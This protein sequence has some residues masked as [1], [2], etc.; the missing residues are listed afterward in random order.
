MTKVWDKP[1]TKDTDW[2]G[3]ASTGGLPVSGRMIQAFIKESLALASS[4]EDI[5]QFVKDYLEE[6]GMASDEGFVTLATEQIIKAVK[7]FEKG[8]KINGSPLITFDKDL[9]A[10]ILRANLVTE[11]GV[12][13]RALLDEIKVPTIM[14]GIVT[15]E[16]TISK[17]DGVL[18]V[19]KAGLDKEEL[20][21]ILE[22]E[23]YVTQS[24]VKSYN[25]EELKKYV[26]KTDLP[27]DIVTASSDQEITGIKNFAN[28][29]EIAGIK[30]YN[31]QDGT[32][33]LDGN[34]V[35]SGGIT[36]RGT[37]TTTTPSLFEALPIDGR[38]I[39]RNA[40]GV[41]Y[42]DEDA[43]N[44]S[45][46][47]GVADS[48]E[49]LNIT[50]KPEWIGAS[51]PSY[52][53]SEIDE[54]PDL[55]IYA[56]SESVTEALTKY[57]PLDTAQ[58]ITA[59]HDFKKGLLID[60]LAIYKSTTDTIYIDANVVVR[61]GV[62]SRGTNKSITPSIFESLP[63]DEHTIKRNENGVLYVDSSSLNIGGGGGGNGD[64]SDVA[65][66]LVLERLADLNSATVG[67]FFT[68]ATGDDSDS[69][70]RPNKG[71][72]TGLT[73]GLDGQQL[74]A[75][76]LAFDASENVYFRRAQGGTWGSWHQFLTEDNYNLYA[77][78]ITGGTVNGDVTISGTLAS[79]K[80]SVNNTSA[81]SGVF[82]TP[83]T[84]IAIASADG[85]GLVIH[86]LATASEN[87][88]LLRVWQG[89]LTGS[90]GSGK[91][92]FSIQSG[93]YTN[94]NCP[95]NAL[96]GIFVGSANSDV[97]SASLY[98]NRSSRNYIASPTG[99][100]IAIHP[101]G[102]L[103]IDSLGYL[104]DGT[105]FYPASNNAYSLGKEGYAWNKI[106][107]TTIN[108][109]TINGGSINLAGDLYLPYGN[110]VI[111]PSGNLVGTLKFGNDTTNYRSIIGTAS[112]K[113]LIISNASLR[114]WKGSD[115]KEY[116]IF[117]SSMTSISLPR[118]VATGIGTTSQS[119]YK[120]T[121]NGIDATFGA[122]DTSGGPYIWVASNHAL[123][124]ATNGAER[125]RITN[126][127]NV[128]IG[129]Q[130]AS[131]KFYVY[132]TSGW[133]SAFTTTNSAV[134]VSHADGYGLS[135]AS[136]ATASENKYLLRV[137]QGS[138]SGSVGTGEALFE[139]RSN[140]IVSVGG[141]LLVTGGITGR[142]TSDR[143]LKENIRKFSASKILM[144]LG[145]VYEYEY[146][147]SEVQKNHIYEGTHYGLIY[148][149]VKGTTLDVMCHENENG[150]GSLNYLE[151]S[152]ISLIAGATMENVDEIAKLKKENRALSKRVE[153][154]ERRV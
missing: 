133:T 147:D 76:Q 60:G 108:C 83:K 23:E 109:T 53:Y 100:K 49:W 81:W 48:V 72:I 44:I 12:I 134:G 79:A 122:N 34:L 67:R 57:V 39:K 144:S 145:G 26:L 16:D 64:A 33:F 132:N 9:N 138:L 52:T 1:I 136:L 51:K 142:Y 56:T 17:A 87:K 11:G 4:K 104:F 18:R 66:G 38:T 125:M 115:S 10:F 111:S 74:Y 47:G 24:W 7:D 61:G 141:N 95:L 40:E 146:I 14:D 99:S 112:L 22:E 116:D 154:L 29:F 110:R 20:I 62:T 80:F 41:L 98:M 117:D 73:L 90:A 150:Y 54:T 8:L 71:W 2:G 113:T 59:Q 88:Y 120:V 43:L 135:I 32:I 93:G 97:A 68:S 106:Y 85:Y 114:L 89:S 102:I 50:G 82:N 151:P 123:R 19:L 128:V 30:F 127:G 75:R 25:A 37:N 148:Q 63:I 65:N 126:D 149:N 78:S 84:N 3:D 69:G 105:A 94:I 124:F 153:Q 131:A 121:G 46:G 143:R 86:S 140:K 35:A 130:T 13:S 92:L 129:E 101:D 139:V 6:I 31:S 28:G 58:P 5:E 27:S 107:A 118:Y 103:R 137:W 70:N 96:E 77:L 119:G 91:E 36:S 152:F 45:T 21:N 42:V 55:T 15:D